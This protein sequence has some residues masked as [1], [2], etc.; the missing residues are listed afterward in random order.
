MSE[1]FLLEFNSNRC[2]FI[3]IYSTRIIDQSVWIQK[4][5]Y[6]LRYKV[7]DNPTQAE[8]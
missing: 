3:F 6:V 4:Q 7:Y 8:N 1:K 2:S 5:L